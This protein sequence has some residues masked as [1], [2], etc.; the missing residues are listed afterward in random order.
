MAGGGRRRAVGPGLTPRRTAASSEH[1][2][3]RVRTRLESIPKTHEWRRWP[4][5]LRGVRMQGLSVSRYLFPPRG[6]CFHETRL[7]TGA[8]GVPAPLRIGAASGAPRRP[9][10]FRAGAQQWGARGSITA[11]RRT[12]HI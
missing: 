9:V 10:P 6:S 5:D 3:Q 1:G 7:P 2:L 11:P 4:D 8:A 12:V